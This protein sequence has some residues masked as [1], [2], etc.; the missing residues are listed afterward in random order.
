M[1]PLRPTWNAWPALKS[2]LVI[3]AWAVIAYVALVGGCN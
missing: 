3:Y 2:T 1:T